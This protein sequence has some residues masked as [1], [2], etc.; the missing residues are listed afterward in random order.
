MVSQRS[1]A[2]NHVAN[3]NLAEGD[4]D[5]VERIE[6]WERLERRNP[7]DGTVVN[8]TATSRPKW[9]LIEEVD[10]ITVVDF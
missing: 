8:V 3:H 2:S 4:E 9:P 10:C 7:P 6:G 5:P 1:R